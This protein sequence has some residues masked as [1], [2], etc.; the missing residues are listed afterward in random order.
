MTCCYMLTWLEKDISPTWL[1][2]KLQHDLRKKCVCACRYKPQ[3][4]GKRIL[5][6]YLLGGKIEFTLA[7]KWHRSWR[8]H[9]NSQSK[10]HQN[11]ANTTRLAADLE[12]T[13]K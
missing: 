13:L 12:H 2:G 4:S 8:K 1:T 11:K 9:F 10:L 3:T 6:M 7:E 5:N